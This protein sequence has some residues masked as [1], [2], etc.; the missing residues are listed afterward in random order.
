MDEELLRL[1]AA[2]FQCGYDDL[3]QRHKEQKMKK[4]LTASLAASAIFLAFG[5]VSTTMAI[6]IQSQKEQIQAQSNDL[7]TMKDAL[8]K[9]V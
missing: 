7:S 2:M 4:M 8:T 5:A 9:Y 3:K 6:R 1:T